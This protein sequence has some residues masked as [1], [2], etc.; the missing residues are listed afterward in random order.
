MPFKRKEIKMGVQMKGKRGGKRRIKIE[1]EAVN[2]KK[3]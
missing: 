3:I 2:C 1:R